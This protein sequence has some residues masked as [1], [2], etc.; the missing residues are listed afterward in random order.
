VRD[1]SCRAGSCRGDEPQG[2]PVRARRKTTSNDPGDPLLSGVKESLALVEHQ[3][4]R[5]RQELWWSQVPTAVPM[6]VFFLHVAR[7]MPDWLDFLSSATFSVVFVLA[8][9]SYIYYMSQ[10][11]ARRYYEP[12]RQ[13]LLVCL[14]VSVMK[15]GA[16]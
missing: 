12:Q 6:P 5:P 2:S 9:Y 1:G 3:I 7:Q 16:K 13:E 11:I 10:R 14:P 4:R 8:P 15:R